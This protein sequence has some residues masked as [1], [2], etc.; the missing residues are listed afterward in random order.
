MQ[1]TE[2]PH[3][4]IAYDPAQTNAV[5]IQKLVQSGRLNKLL[6]LGPVTKAEA[7]AREQAGERPVAVT[8]RTPEGLEVKAAAGTGGTAASQVAALERTKAHP[9][10]T[11]QVET[12]E[13][14]LAQR[15]EALSGAGGAAKGDGP[16]AKVAHAHRAAHAGKE[17][18]G[19]GHGHSSSAGVEKVTA[20]NSFTG[21]SITRNASP[22]LGKEQYTSAFQG[23][24]DTR[25]GIFKEAAKGHSAKTVEA[26]KSLNHK[27][28]SE[29]NS[30][31][32]AE[33]HIKE[34]V[35]SLKITPAA[36]KAMMA[37]LME[38]KVTWKRKSPTPKA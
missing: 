33:H 19:S 10:N 29:V 37:K 4:T 8:E 14:V 13:N 6:D 28:D 15:L 5:A 24:V 34:A 16:M 2:T 32:T 3:G 31:H 36:K 22:K 11:V 21:K 12:P 25:A 27:L 30:R 17:S 18:H 38:A 26:L 23:R 20:H 35:S 7:T 1:T 9:D